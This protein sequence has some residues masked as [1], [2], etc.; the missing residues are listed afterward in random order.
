MN[1]IDLLTR[2]FERPDLVLFDREGF[3]LPV[4]KGVAESLSGST[5]DLQQL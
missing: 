3:E 1:T 5:L 2:E 4:L